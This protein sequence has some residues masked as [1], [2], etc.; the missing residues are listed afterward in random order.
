MLPPALLPDC[1]PA[2]AAVY[3]LDL[4]RAGGQ[5]GDQVLQLL[6]PLLEEPLLGKVVHCCEQVGAPGSAAAGC[7][8]EA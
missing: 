5:A 1:T 4:A 2:P 7:T 8:S 6:R 3:L